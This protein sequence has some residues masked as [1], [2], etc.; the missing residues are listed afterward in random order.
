MRL[1][2][3][4]DRCQGLLG[5]AAGEPTSEDGGR[6][7][8]FLGWCK[9]RSESQGA[10]DVDNRLR[11]RCNSSSESEA[12]IDDRASQRQRLFPLSLL[13]SARGASRPAK[14]KRTSKRRLRPEDD[15]AQLPLWDRSRAR[16][17]S[18]TSETSDRGI[19]PVLHCW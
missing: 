7:S 11:Q 19:A 13:R 3:N 12:E 14:A 10:K 5:S 15:D 9:P 4:A 18:E 2:G 16:K 17:G 1:S 8:S 6:V